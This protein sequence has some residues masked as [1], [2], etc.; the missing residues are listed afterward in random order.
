MTVSIDPSDVRQHA[1]VKVRKTSKLRILVGAGLGSVALAAFTVGAFSFFSGLA[2]PRARNTR[3]APVASMPDLK[4]GLPE[5]R[6][7]DATA[8]SAPVLNLPKPP[9]AVATAAEAPIEPAT[10]R[11]DADATGSVAKPPAAKQSA[12]TKAVPQIENAPVVTAE[13]NPS[14]VIAPSKAETVQAKPVETR[15]V[16]AIVA[17]PAKPETTEDVAPPAQP[18]A[19]APAKPA[20]K[21]AES[22]KPAKAAPPKA[23]AAK[24]A[25]PSR[26]VATAAVAEATPAAVTHAAEPDDDGIGSK[27]KSGI[28][29]IFGEE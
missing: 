10:L 27:L 4:D 28:Q 19:S 16:A 7:A 15:A 14:P 2:D 18:Q 21:A 6:Q 13:P 25:K 3:P 22:K 9:A 1:T 8:P 11:S 29:A 24:P 23:A 20:E 26:N 12:L 17:P 5:L